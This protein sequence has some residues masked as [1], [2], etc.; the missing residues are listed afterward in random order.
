MFHSEIDA[1]NAAGLANATRGKESGY[2]GV[3]ECR[4]RVCKK[5]KEEKE[6]VVPRSKAPTVAPRTRV[7]PR[8]KMLD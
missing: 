5:P 2:Y 7:S 8:P 1:L 4:I 6:V 3:E